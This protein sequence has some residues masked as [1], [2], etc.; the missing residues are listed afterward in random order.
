MSH[1][2]KGYVVELLLFAALFFI[3]QPVKA[4]EISFPRGHGAVPIDWQQDKGSYLYN[5][6]HLPD[7]RIPTKYHAIKHEIKKL[8]DPKICGNGDPDYGKIMVYA[9]D[10]SGRAIPGYI[11]DAAPYFSSGIA[12]SCPYR[13]CD[14]TQKNKDINGADLI[15]CSIS[16]YLFRNPTQVFSVA[17]KEGDCPAS[18]DANTACIPQCPANPNN[19]PALF[20][21]NLGSPVMSSV[22][23]YKWAFLSTDEYLS[24]TADVKGA[25]GKAVYRKPQVGSPDIPVMVLDLGPGGDCGEDEMKLWT[26][27]S[28]QDPFKNRCIK[29]FQFTESG[30]LNMYSPSR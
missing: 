17:P 18:P 4:K 27:P 29:F 25:N 21:Y 12:S 22:P 8:V 6:G 26:D 15:P 19:C 11:L 13:M 10:F 7:E 30:F 23:V 14:Y 5:W 16:I 2:Q 9:I 1:R 3:A 20:K 24:L 28:L